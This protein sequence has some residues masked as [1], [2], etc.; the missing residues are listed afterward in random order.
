MNFYELLWTVLIN[1]INVCMLAYEFYLTFNCMTNEDL[2]C[3]NQS[4][5]FNGHSRH[6]AKVSMLC[7]AYVLINIYN[8]I[9][10]TIHM[11]S[12]ITSGRVLNGELS[13][14]TTFDE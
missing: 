5:L 9:H 3:M 2:N 13:L 1:V 14:T 4:S 7:F 10:N 8:T 12:G 6:G 11:Y